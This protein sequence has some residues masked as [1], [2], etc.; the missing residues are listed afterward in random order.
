MLHSPTGNNASQTGSNFSQTG[1]NASQT[2]GN[3]SQTGSGVNILFPI[4]IQVL[5]SFKFIAFVIQNESI[6]GYSV[7]ESK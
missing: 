2:G 3:A 6:A 7:H 5:F 4:I 1:S